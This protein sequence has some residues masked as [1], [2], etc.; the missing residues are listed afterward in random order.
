M[1]FATLRSKLYTWMVDQS[2]LGSD[3][4]IEADQAEHRPARPYGTY[5]VTSPKRVG[6]TDQEVMVAGVL[7]VS[8][9]REITASLNVFGAGALETMQKLRDS[10]ELPSVRD[11]YFTAF[12]L[13][14][15]EVSEV[16]DLTELEDTKFQQRAQ[17]DV[18]VGL[19][20]N[21]VDSG[22]GYIEDVVLNA[23]LIDT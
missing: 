17:M 14:V 13:A 4:V 16:R 18:V 10:L 21:L 9:E 5:K 22:T 8:G 11:T 12:D 7:N 15:T 19:T 3:R 1:D 20:S 23:V 6:G 2:A